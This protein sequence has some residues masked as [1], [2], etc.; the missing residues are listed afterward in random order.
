MSPYSRDEELDSLVG[1]IAAIAPDTLL[2]LQPVTP[3]GPVRE[4]PTAGQLLTWLRRCRGRLPDVRVI[5]QT[6]KSLGVL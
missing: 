3:S 2:V 4:A 1:C 5:P 6:H